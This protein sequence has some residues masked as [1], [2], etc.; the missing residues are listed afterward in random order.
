MPNRSS[1]G[2]P[3]S[4]GLMIGANA[5]SGE[6]DAWSASVFFSV[7][8]PPGAD[9]SLPCET[10][11]RAA[12][13]TVQ[14]ETSGS[15]ER[16]QSRVEVPVKTLPA[17]TDRLRVGRGVQ[18]SPV[19]LGM[20]SAWRVVGAAFEAGINTFF[21]TADMHWPLYEPLRKGLRDLLRK[22]NVRSQISVVATA[23]VTR[24]TSASHRSKKCSRPCRG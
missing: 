8:S 5:G 6:H 2:A 12:S 9:P 4:L 21:L 10:T 1:R 18:L 17:L 15:R 23:Y 3:R 11:A 14:Y 19:C 22:K 7:R 16:C 13:D 20:T 24:Q